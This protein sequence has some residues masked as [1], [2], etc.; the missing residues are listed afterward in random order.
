MSPDK[1]ALVQAVLDFIFDSC[2][3]DSNGNP[4]TDLERAR[5]YTRYIGWLEGNVLECLTDEQ[6]DRL[7]D[8]VNLGVYSH[9]V[10]EAVL[11]HDQDGSF[12]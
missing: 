4:R 6:A 2:R 3:Y 10:D 7:V 1:R 12:Y 8:R 11:H 5:E 9:A